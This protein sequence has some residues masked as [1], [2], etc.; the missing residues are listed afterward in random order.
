MAFINVSD[1]SGS[2]TLVNFPSTYKNYTF[3]K[4]DIIDIKAR[5]ERRNSEYQ[6]SL[7]SFVK[8]N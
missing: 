2:I 6:L 1:E 3:S 7:I 8:K 4:G 5:V